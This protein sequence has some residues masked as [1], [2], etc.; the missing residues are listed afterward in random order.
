MGYYC[1][2]A[3][4]GKFEFREDNYKAIHLT[5]KAKLDSDDFSGYVSNLLG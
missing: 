1:Q 5:P 4:E 3:V 2:R